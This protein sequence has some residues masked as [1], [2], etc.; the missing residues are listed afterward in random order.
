MLLF[1]R[2]KEHE[3]GWVGMWGHM[4][5]ELGEREECDIYIIYYIHYQ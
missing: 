4:W 2:E 5:E 3:A 1:L